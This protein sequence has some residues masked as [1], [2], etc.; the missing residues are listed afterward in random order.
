MTG[1]HTKR[2][3]Y[4]KTDTQVECHVNEKAETG[5]KHL[6]AKEHQRLP[7][8]HWKLRKRHEQITSDS[9]RKES[10]LLI[11]LS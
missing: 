1:V 4:E 6:Q 2:M 3:P 10:T 7:S 5:P 11:P 8:N 9:P